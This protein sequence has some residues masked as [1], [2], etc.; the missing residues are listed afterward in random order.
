MRRLYGRLF[1]AI[2]AASA[3]LLQA[4]GG[5]DETKSLESAKAN[6]AKQDYRT[7]AI[8][9]KSLIQS[10]PKSAEGR[11]LLGTALLGSG[12][13][14]GAIQELEKAKELGYSDAWV[15]PEMAR[16]MAAAGQS[17]KVIDRFSTTQLP[18]AK[19]SAS[20]RA[21]VAAALFAKGQTKAGL[22]A[23]DAA[24]KFDAKNIAARMLRSRILASQGS[25]DEALRWV[26]EVI[27]EEPKRLEALHLKGEIVWLKTSDA[28]AALPVFRQALAID[29]KYPPAHRSI[30]RIQLHQRDLPGFRAQVAAL[31]QASPEAIDVA[32]FETQAA[33][34][35]GDLKKA[36]ERVQALMKLSPD[37]PV[38]RQLAGAVELRN[39]NYRA[40]EK[41]LSKALQAAPDL[42]AARRLLGQALLQAGEPTRALSVLQP[43]LAQEGA[44]AEVVALAAEAYLTAGDVQKAEQMFGQATK[45][46]GAEGVKA[47][48]ALALMRL[49]K[50]DAT[51]ALSQLEGLANQG[52]GDYADLALISMRMRRGEYA[53]GLAAVDRLERKRPGSAQPHAIRGRI[54]R[55]LKN[56]DGARAAFEKALTVDPNYYPAITELAAMDID[57]RKFDVAMKRLQDAAA[58]MPT[59]P[60][61]WLDQAD[62][63][64]KAGAK[65]DEIEGLLRKASAADAGAALPRFML[66][67]HLLAQRQAKEALSVAREAAAALPEDQSL[68]FALGRAQMENGDVQQAIATFIKVAA[69]TPNSSEPLMGLASAYIAN[70]DLVSARKTYRRALEISPDY[71]PAIQGLVKV[72]LAD[73]QFDEA[74]QIARALQKQQPKS[75]RGYQIEAD[76]HASQR[77]WEPA[78]KALREALNKRASTDIAIRLHV[79]YAMADRS[80]EGD[81]FAEGWLRAHPSDAGFHSHLGW[82]AVNRKD[83]NAAESAYRKVLQL[84]PDDPASLNN[85]ASVMVAKKAPGALALAE[86]AN[87]LAPDVPAFL[88]T[89]ASALAFEGQMDKAVEQQRK[90]ADLAGSEPAFRLTLA[91]LLLQQ[92]DKVK[93][94]AELERLKALGAKFPGHAEVAELLKSVS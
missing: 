57:A 2:F 13:A 47:K 18:D 26:D 88:D 79:L 41:H 49:A 81:R 67:D 85:L 1:C 5:F 52:A 77:A 10:N 66:V 42:P 39:G 90:A 6:L 45:L 32:L 48:T 82:M 40:A 84:R 50:G 64:R 56:P 9:L 76:I 4:C 33:L 87:K 38:I 16:A 35:E 94:K 24:L 74:L 30:I 73:K 23:A 20:L 93:A 28:K 3:L 61:L 34:L 92:G 17:Q 60:R 8:E 46:E 11:Y 19:S 31:K 15:L 14:P 65:P 78:V 86:K 43:L 75:P 7:A 36:G 27:A 12:D 63:R 58:R 91:K 25:Y 89:W 72:S 44:S 22:E 37:H 59:D 83:F 51:A 70:R 29:P 54:Q 21:L 55:L 80:S 62:V 53:E 69:A 71:L 68:Q